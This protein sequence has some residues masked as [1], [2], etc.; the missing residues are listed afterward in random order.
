MEMYLLSKNQRLSIDARVQT[1]RVSGQITYHTKSLHEEREE[2]VHVI[3]AHGD[4]CTRKCV[5]LEKITSPGN[6]FVT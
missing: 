3:Y 1:T 6:S 4:I 2:N 5:A